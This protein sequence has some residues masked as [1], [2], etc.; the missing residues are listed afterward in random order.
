[1]IVPAEFLPHLENNRESNKGLNMISLR[2]G[3]DYEPTDKGAEKVNSEGLNSQD[4]TPD[5]NSLSSM[6]SSNSSTSHINSVKQVLFQE[7]TPKSLQWNI[8]IFISV[9][10]CYITICCVNQVLNYQKQQD[11]RTII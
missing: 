10:L 1:M 8:V 4:E 2:N 7:R 9:M 6:S 3:T 11:L 5:I